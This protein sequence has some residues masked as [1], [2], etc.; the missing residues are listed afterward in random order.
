MHPTSGL[1][2]VVSEPRRA[3][4]MARRMAVTSATVATG[5]LLP[6]ALV[7]A[8][9]ERLVAGRLPSR[10]PRSRMTLSDTRA[11]CLPSG[12]SPSVLEFH[13][14]SRATRGGCPEARRVADCHRR[15]GFSPTPEH[16]CSDLSV[17]RDR[18]DRVIGR[19]TWEGACAWGQVLG[20]GGT[21]RP[22]RGR[23]AG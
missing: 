20:R 19:R 17:A 21:P 12:L 4:A 6:R 23:R 10:P 1:G 8:P 14:I 13:Q 22:P 15:F 11:C 9:G 5:L 7:R 2:G 18:D 16:A 3:C